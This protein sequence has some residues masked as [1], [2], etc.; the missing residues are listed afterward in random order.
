M[1]RICTTVLLAMG[2]VSLSAFAW[3]RDEA[4]GVAYTVDQGQ[5]V[6]VRIDGD[7]AQMLYQK[8]LDQ[9]AKEGRCGS[10]TVV[11]GQNLAC[12][13]ST[14]REYACHMQVQGTGKAVVPYGICPSPSIIGIGDLDGDQH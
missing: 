4:E 3:E 1:K 14:D 8:I 2:T 6:R 13:K 10:N 5:S 11:W 7:A 9:G 12:L